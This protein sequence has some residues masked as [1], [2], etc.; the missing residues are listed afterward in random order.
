MAF[1]TVDKRAEVACWAMFVTLIPSV[2]A[3]TYQQILHQTSLAHFE[4]RHSRVAESITLKSDLIDIDITQ[5]IV[6]NILNKV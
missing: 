3:A 5:T 4:F 1:R 6:M 2:I